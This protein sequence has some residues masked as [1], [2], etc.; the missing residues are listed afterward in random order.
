MSE[1]VP[2]L[3]LKKGSAKPLHA[4]HPWVFAGAV[5]RIEGPGVSPGCEV[6]VVDER[7]TCVGRGFYS[8][9]SAIAV[10]LI[11]RADAPITPALLAARIDEA[12]RLRRD[13]LALGVA[14]PRATGQGAAEPAQAA[15]A[16]LAQA[17]RA[18]PPASPALNA[19][20]SNLLAELDAQIAKVQSFA[21]QY[22]M[23]AL[24]ETADLRRQRDALL[25]EAPVARASSPVSP[26]VALRAS[27]SGDMSA[28]YPTT[29]YRLVN[30]EGDGL[31]GLVVDIYGDYAAVQIGTPGM[32][33]QQ[34]TI[35]DALSSRLPLKGI[36]D[37]SD[38]H[39]RQLEKM[40]PPSAAPL[41]GEVPAAPFPVYECGIEMACDLRLGHGQK[42]GLY[43]DQRDNR[44]RFAAL[45]P[46]RNVLDVFCHG[47]GFALH[48]ARAGARSITLLDSSAA[49]L[50]LAQ[51]NLERNHIAD[52][53]LIQAEWTEG[54]KHLRE[55]GR[56]FELLVLDPPKFARGKENVPQALSAYRD[57]N[58]QAARLLAPGGI[59]FTC[60]CSGNVSEVDF[61]R[62][63]A[64]GLRLSERRALL[65]ERRGAAPDHPVPP[66]FDQGRYLTCLVLQVV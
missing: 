54:F 24:E 53:D 61:E 38:N 65:L 19:Q 14:F 62:A 21:A 59:L 36:V 6:R 41:F 48:A 45:A 56:L 3:H 10:R 55:Q 40:D 16:E 28:V 25:S 22:G 2:T 52:A 29:A 49:A 1:G 9:H 30:S 4:G 63:V 64:A 35:L 31:G 44:R 13:V 47:G 39:A 60:S 17:A 34:Q 7:G 18:T 20:D 23:D 46:G 50:E 15:H 32:A 33:R 12:L 51:A 57:L 58:A 27:A 37:R 11:T 26:P 66:G 8:P 42:T 43:L 5:A